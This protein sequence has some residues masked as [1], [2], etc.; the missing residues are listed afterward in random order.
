MTARAALGTWFVAVFS[1]ANLADRELFHEVQRPAGADFCAGAL[2]ADWLAALPPCVSSVALGAGE[3]EVSVSGRPW[4]MHVIDDGLRGADGVRLADVNGDRLP[5]IATGWEES[6]LTRVYLHPG[7]QGVC[8]RWPAVTVGTTPQVEDAVF[9]D[10]DGDGRHDVVSC[11]EGR[12]RT[13]FVHWAPRSPEDYLDPAAWKTEPIPASQ[14]RQMWMF[15]LPVQIDGRGAVDLVAAGKGE[16]AEIG[17][18]EAPENPRRL[19]DWRWH[20]MSPAGWVMSLIGIDVDADGDTDIATTD[21]K[22]PQRACR[23]LE[24]P[25][26][27][28]SQKQPWTNHTVGGTD[29]EMMFMTVA[30]LDGDGLQDMLAA[31]KPEPLLLFRR[32][33]VG[34]PAWQPCRIPLPGGIGTGKGV[35]VGDL[36]GDGRS[37]VVF[38]CEHAQ[39]D[40]A[41][42]MWL[43]PET[44]PVHGKWT[45]R[46]ISGPAGIKFDRIELVDLD[47]DGDLDVMTCEES[48]PVNGQRQ[49]LGV[50]WY[51]NP[52]ANGNRR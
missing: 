44:S 49:G 42:V 23:W 38:S 25:G 16:G 4:R 47:A 34:P 20:T 30:D 9:V 22:G 5:D 11:C 43:R 7:R 32:R 12:K 51:E 26:P 41:G 24:N 10:L 14:G 8:K 36:D 17:W 50:I 45:A 31:V 37:D 28:A 1:I 33:A 15:C 21:R 40:K 35:A 52:A 39:G 48:E 27:G 29:S 13:M 6:G 19:A 2:A 46:R 3:G 18:F